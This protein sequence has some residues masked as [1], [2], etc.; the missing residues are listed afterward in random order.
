MEDIDQKDVGESKYPQEI[1]EDDNL[2]EEDNK[3]VVTV[4]CK[5][6]SEELKVRNEITEIA[7]QYNESETIDTDD[8]GVMK[9]IDDK[10]TGQISNMLAQKFGTGWSVLVG[11]RFAAGLGLKENDKFGNFKI[12]LFNI[13]I[14]QCNLRP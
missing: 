14:F 3:C 1:Q 6:G 12:G 7:K 5:M 11:N 13:L 9:E 4:D 10:L 2:E 8:E